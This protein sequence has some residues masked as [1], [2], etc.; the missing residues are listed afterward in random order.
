MEYLSSLAK[1]LKYQLA[2]YLSNLRRQNR[3]SEYIT[4]HKIKKLQ[5]GCGDNKLHSW[6][7]SDK[8]G[9]G[10]VV[11]ID[12][13]RKL[14]LSDSSFHYVFCEHLIEHLTQDQGKKLLAEIFRILKSRGKVRIAT[15]DLKFLIDLYKTKKNYHSKKIYPVDY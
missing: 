9:I 10:S 3:F 7:N 2:V 6:L 13:T 11:P 8:N 5:L 14:P 15:P 12:V 1:L 4:L